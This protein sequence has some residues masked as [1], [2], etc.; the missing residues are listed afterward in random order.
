VS[1]KYWYADVKQKKFQLGCKKIREVGLLVEVKTE[2]GDPTCPYGGC[3]KE[4]VTASLASQP[5]ERFYMED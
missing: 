5:R 1:V 3:V 2:A 4:D